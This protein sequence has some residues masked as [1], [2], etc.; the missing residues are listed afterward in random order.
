MVLAK[1]RSLSLAFATLLVTLFVLSTVQAQPYDPAVFERVLVPI[2]TN[3]APGLHGTLWSTELWYRNNS[4]FPVAVLPT[5]EGDSVPTIGIM[6]PLRIPIRPPDAP[7]EFLYVTR[8][9]LDQV[10]FD[11][12]L[13]NRADTSGDF[14]TKLPVVREAEFSQQIGLINIATDPN[15]RISLRIYGLS[16]NITSAT[17]RIYSDLNANLASADVLLSGSPRYAEILLLGERFPAI[18]TKDRVRI[19]VQ[20]GQ[21]GRLWAF[22]TVTSNLTQ[23]V[24][25]ITPQ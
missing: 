1:S 22:A 16:D 18:R 21:G 8:G 10:Q 17:V 25:V 19:D 6:A 20:A 2:S 7:G 24:A 11:L 12:R 15:Q 4:N 23:H 5:T 13:Y 3:D 9:Y 14:G